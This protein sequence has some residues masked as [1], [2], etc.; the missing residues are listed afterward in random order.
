LKGKGCSLAVRIDGKAY[1]VEGVSMDQY[2]DAHEKDGLCVAVRKAEV[3][4]KIVKDKFRVSYF[5]L[6][7][8]N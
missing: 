2:G 8:A 4:G 1:F 3:Q 7:P 5:K 6:L